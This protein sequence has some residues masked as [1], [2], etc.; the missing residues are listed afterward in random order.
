MKINFL[1]LPERKSFF[2]FL[3]LTLF[4]C[5]SSFALNAQETLFPEN[6]KRTEKF[7]FNIDYKKSSSELCFIGAKY[8]T[9]KSSQRSNLSQ[10]RHSHPYTQREAPLAIAEL[11]ILYGSSLLM[12]QEYFTNA[13]IYGF[14]NNLDLIHSFQNKNN[15]DRITLTPLDVKNK[16][17]II[18]AFESVGVQYDLI[19]DDT[20]HQFEDQLR[21]IQNC[22]SYLKP[23]G[24]LII[25]DIFKS[26][27]E[28][29][30][31]NRLQPI[32]DQF[33]DFYFV[34]LDHEN[35]YS[36]G[37]DNDKLFVLVKEG[38]PPIFGNKK[39]MTI[40][41]PS[42]R[43][44]NLLKVKESIDFNY[45]DEW[46]IVYDE[47]KVNKHPHLF[48]NENNPKIKEYLHTSKGKFGN[49]QRNYALDHIQN[50]ETFLYF[51][52][53]DNLIHQDLYRLLDIVDD[54]KLYTFNQEKRLLGN[55]IKLANIDTAMILI[56][57]KL[58]KNIKWVLNDYGADF[59]FINQCY[60]ENPDEWVYVNNSLSTY[61]ILN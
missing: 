35:R 33:Q 26:F 61:N 57:F 49:P 24:M 34:T 13:T 19:I 10:N 54:E 44:S 17:S 59:I 47:A 31:I 60:S 1:L 58:C 12:W 4:S 28:E 30:Y 52:D 16:T 56:N 51:L 6:V 32:L 37:W 20:T 36:P 50:E 22:Y 46:I 18:D 9:D 8:D 7:S 27:S 40:I 53:D 48:K 29:D 15:N 14:E 39:K 5:V 25:E 41:T 38:A 42:M 3:M 21:I 11:G 23:G 45:V 2:L 55:K 43:P